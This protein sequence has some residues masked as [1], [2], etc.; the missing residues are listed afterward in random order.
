MALTGG[1]AFYER[2]KCLFE[3]GTL[4][5]ASSGD[6]AAPRCLDRNPVNYWRSSGSDDAT[7]ETLEITFTEEMTFNRIFLIDHNFKA[8]NIQYWNGAAYVDF[9][10]VVGLD[11]SLGVLAESAYSKD[12][13]YY[14]FASVTSTK[15]QLEIDTTQVVDAEKYLNQLVVTTELGT[16]V[17]YPEIRDTELSRNIRNEKML[18]GRT[19]S[20]KS[21]ESMKVKFDFRNYPASLSNDIDLIFRLHDL[22]ATFMLW[23]CGGRYGSNYFRK[24]LRGYR[25]RDLIPVELTQSLKPIYSD[26]VY[27]NTVNFS[28]SFEETVG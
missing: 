11:G 14:E 28:A 15:I 17:G 3:D 24:Q 13:S 18:S 7:T 5:T 22:D 1:A 27:V 8:Y 16:L 21:D 12:T 10:S 25:L 4:I 9:T 2:S 6:P 23:I 19:L 20:I 26:N